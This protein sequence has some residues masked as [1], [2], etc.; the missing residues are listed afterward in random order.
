MKPTVTEDIKVGEGVEILSESKI[1]QNS[2]PEG[3]PTL[4]NA[5][6]KSFSKESSKY[7][8]NI[9]ENQELIQ[10]IQTN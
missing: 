1:L 3:I 10:N 9:A 5:L 7:A 4:H 6:G 2:H 8:E